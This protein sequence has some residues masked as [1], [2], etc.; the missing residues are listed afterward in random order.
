MEEGGVRRG[1]AAGEAYGTTRCCV[2]ASAGHTA[3]VRMQAANEEWSC[4]TPQDAG[5]RKRHAGGGAAVKNYR[6]HQ[7][8]TNLMT[9]MRRR[10][11]LAH[12][13]SIALITLATAFC[14]TQNGDMSTLGAATRARHSV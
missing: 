6:R 4:V 13:G 14:A 9:N 11:I 12:C 7:P 1:N 2:K 3:L 10:S 5:Q 8:L